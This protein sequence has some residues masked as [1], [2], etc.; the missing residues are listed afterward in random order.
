MG[1]LETLH[2]PIHVNNW[3]GHMSPASVS[4]FD[5]MFW[6]HHANVDRQM[7][8]YQAVFPSSYVEACKAS[9]PTYTI[10]E[11]EMLDANSPLTPFHRTAA[12]DWWT[13]ANSRNIE[14][15][16]YT[17]P[18]LVGRPD[19]TTLKASI[20]RQYAG[21]STISASGK[22]RRE[23]SDS[24][25]GTANGRVYLAQVK[26][27]IFGF[28]DGKGS[29]QP[30]NVVTFLGDVPEDPKAWFQS[31]SFV[32]VTSMT[33][34]KNME[35]DQSTTILVELT[36]ALEKNGKKSDDAAVEY[37]KKSLKWRLG[38]VSLLH[39]ERSLLGEGRN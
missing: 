31:E 28:A 8:L 34:G 10:E 29:S 20:Q 33:G 25:T 1:S 11:G 32:A 35:G 6:L 3:P 7:A 17:Y 39:A 30:Y 37:L 22:E 4:A 19:N 26:L 15:M 18:E 38:L 14:E 2:N 21:S 27:P 24:E 9:T 23:E 16:G 12:G 13:S 5:P 36:G